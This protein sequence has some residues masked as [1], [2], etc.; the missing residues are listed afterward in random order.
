MKISITP[1]N[2]NTIATRVATTVSDLG[3]AKHGKA[4]VASQAL[5]VLSSVANYRDEHS[6][7]AAVKAE[8]LERSDDSGAA[9]LTLLR[10]LVHYMTRNYDTDLWDSTTREF[11]DEAAT[12]LGWEPFDWQLDDNSNDLTDGARTLGVDLN[13]LV[14]P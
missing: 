9:A 2:L 12:L 10:G 6:F 5:R 13:D 11:L 7:V 14:K 1:E 4:M 3:F 8:P